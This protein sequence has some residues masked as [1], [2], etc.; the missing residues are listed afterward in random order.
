MFARESLR[1]RRAGYFSETRQAEMKI[2]RARQVSAETEIYTD[3][4]R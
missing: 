2:K 3:L 1:I 4:R